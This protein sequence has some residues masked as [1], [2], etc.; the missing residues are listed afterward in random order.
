MTIN[1]II[2]SLPHSIVDESI[3][4]HHFVNNISQPHYLL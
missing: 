2:N 3:G 4:L 1:L